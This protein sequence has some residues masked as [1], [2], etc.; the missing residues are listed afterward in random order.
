MHLVMRLVRALGIAP[1]FTT[2]AGDSDAVARA[3]T[4]MR[5]V[6][7]RTPPR[8]VRRGRHHE[9]IDIDGSD[10]HLLG[11]PGL[12][13]RVV[14]YFHGGGYTIGP[15]QPHWT[16]LTELGDHAG[17][18]AAMLLY[19]RTPEADSHAVI[20]AALGAYR[21]LA[22]R[23][24]PNNVVVAGDSAGGGLT[25]SLLLAL[26]EDGAAQP[27]AAILISPWL[28]LALTDPAALAQES[29]D[30]MLSVDGIRAVGEIYAGERRTDDPLI[31][32]IHASLEGLAPMHVF[33]GTD[34]LLLAESRA[35]A[36]RAEVD[37]ATLTLREMPGGQH[38]AA[39]F[40]TRE[41]RAARAQMAALIGWP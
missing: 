5:R 14:L 34:E 2:F 31:S 20:G 6:D 17:A 15:S 40:P 21:H 7:Q 3:A 9:V 19:P 25:A 23:Y 38:C 16:A 33:V 32:P 12:A 24:G 13:R 10:L 26:R 1:D 18:D 4:A 30:L 8:A 28:D 29:T 11:E 27:H 37:G 35:F 36:K 41:G 22:A 39:I